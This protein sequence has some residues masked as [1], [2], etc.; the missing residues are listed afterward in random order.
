L[1][2]QK[3]NRTIWPLAESQKS[4]G[5]PSALALGSFSYLFNKQG[6]MGV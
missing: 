3:H 6:K 4:L 2:E 5:E 1:R